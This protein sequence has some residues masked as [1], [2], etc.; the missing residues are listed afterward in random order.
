MGRMRTHLSL[1][2][3]IPDP[4]MVSPRAWGYY[5][6]PLLCY[7]S[8]RSHVSNQLCSINMGD[9]PSSKGNSPLPVSQMSWKTYAGRPISRPRF[10]PSCQ[11]ITWTRSTSE[12]VSYP[13]GRL[14]ILLRQV[15]VTRTSC[16]AGV[17]GEVKLTRNIFTG[18]VHI[19]TH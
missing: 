15:F 9:L 2:D 6:I 12:A 7:P 5:S 3:K 17:W 14:G 1:R 16:D 19:S 18:P 11:P 8:I 13:D 10:Y 4:I